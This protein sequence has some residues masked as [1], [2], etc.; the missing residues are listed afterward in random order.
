M[1]KT[2][3]GVAVA[4]G[5]TLALAACGGQPSATGQQGGNGSQQGGNGS[6]QGGNGGQNTGHVMAAAYHATQNANSAKINLK[7][8][9]VTGGKTL[10]VDGHGVAQF[11]PPKLALHMS[12]AGQK[13]EERLLDKT[14]YLKTPQ[15]KWIAMDLSKM[16]GQQQAAQS[17]TQALSYLRGAS[18]KV[19]KLGPKTIDGTHTTGYKALVNLDK[20]AAKAPGGQTKKAIEKLEKLTGSHRMPIKVWID[21]KNRL[22]REK[23]SQKLHAGGKNVM[24]RSTMTLSDYGTPVH[25]RKPPAGK[26]TSAPPSVPPA[27]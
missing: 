1:R 16:I 7:I 12:A 15:G 10:H 14:A 19:T 8:T 20:V 6:Q 13:I 11:K 25:V 3:A 5:A 22:V 21:G 17:P 9:T 26:V 27:H 18:E 4:A 2:M 23:T 24:S